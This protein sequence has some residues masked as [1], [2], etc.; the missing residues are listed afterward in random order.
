MAR[1]TEIVPA[2]A[3]A[4]VLGL[5]GCSDKAGPGLAPPEDQKAESP[6]QVVWNFYPQGLTLNILAEESLNEYGGQPN[7]VMLCLYQLNGAASFSSLAELPDGLKAL[8][9]CDKFDQTVVSARRLFIQPG[10][11]LTE[12]YD[13][14][15]SANAVGLAAGYM[16]P[17]PKGSVCRQ[18]FPVRKN[19]AGL[20]FRHAEYTPDPLV[21]DIKLGS[22]AMV[23]RARADGQPD[24]WPRS[25]ENEPP[26]LP[27]PEQ[28]KPALEPEPK[29]DTAPK[30]ASL[31][32][33]PA[34]S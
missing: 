23:C 3:L 15:E 29:K 34:S 11:R 8:L 19:M 20:L 7:A 9:S 6:H 30:P 2:L 5:G 12:V 10:G 27:E 24:P 17:A 16:S 31:N 4:L 25:E 32:E 21:L 26:S 14:L 33:P 22:E 13:R 28:E 1:W 18:A